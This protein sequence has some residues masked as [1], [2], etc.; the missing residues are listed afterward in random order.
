M[1]DYNKSSIQLAIDMVNQAAGTSFRI[2]DITFKDVKYLDEG[3]YNT[4]AKLVPALGSDYQD[5]VV[6]Q[7]DR[8]N[9]DTFF[10]GI[11][12]KVQPAY[13]KMLSDYLPTINETYGLSLTSEDIVDGLIPVDTSPPFKVKITIKDDNPAFYGSFILLV[14]NE[15]KSIRDMVD[16]V[17]FGGIPYPTEN[18]G[19]IQ[20]SLYFY[21]EDWTE[22]RR[23]LESYYVNMF[24]DDRFINEIN[25][26]SN[27]L[28]ISTPN[29]ADFNLYNAKVVHNGQYDR[30]NEYTKKVGFSNVLVI[31][32]DENY[33]KNVGGY[34]VFHYN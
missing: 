21:G 10:R 24:I 17:K 5:P 31:R 22:L 28:W 29:L 26:Y 12:V 25:L 23:L 13:Q 16:G 9:V 2:K 15:R 27:D 1:I 33:C 34:L 18:V 3:Y 8:I 32:L 6:I 30:N 11:E 20:G 19:K 14:T 4:S 7:Y